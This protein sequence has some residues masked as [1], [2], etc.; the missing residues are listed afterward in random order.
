METKMDAATLTS[1]RNGYSLDIDLLPIVKGEVEVPNFEPADL[2]R[3]VNNIAACGHSML[4][5]WGW[6]K[7]E[8]GKNW[9]QFFLTPAPMG[10]ANIG[11]FDGA[12]YVMI[13]SSRNEG[14]VVGRFAICKHEFKMGAGANPSRGWRP[15]SCTKCHLDMTVD[16]SD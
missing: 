14:P 6:A 3:T 8:A 10:N 1:K 12:G 15:G 7:T 5:Q 2:A 11:S 13:Y 4:A 9:A 16:S